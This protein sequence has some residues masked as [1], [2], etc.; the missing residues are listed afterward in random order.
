[1]G[2]VSVGGGG[3]Q[4]SVRPKS[5]AVIVRLMASFCGVDSRSRMLVDLGAG[6]G[7]VL[8]VGSAL[9]ECLVGTE[10]GGQLDYL[11][12]RYNAWRR[13]VGGRSDSVISLFRHEDDIKRPDLQVGVA[14]YHF[15]QTWSREHIR[16]VRK[17]LTTF[18]VDVYV[19]VAPAT[20]RVVVSGYE[21]VFSLRVAMSVSGESKLA[22]VF[23]PIT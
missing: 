23:R 3:T 4:G 6:D 18:G 17:W 9:F 19:S 5:L 10:T 7:R 22:R 12:D 15:H 16:R 11:L 13:A 20:T 2:I 8:V 21:E 14:V 1:L